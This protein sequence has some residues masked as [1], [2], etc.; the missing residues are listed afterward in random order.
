MESG[1]DTWDDQILKEADRIKLTNSA[2]NPVA[3]DAEN[4]IEYKYDENPNS[5]VDVQSSGRYST[6]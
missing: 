3:D 5:R 1:P 2:A 6:N 4:Y